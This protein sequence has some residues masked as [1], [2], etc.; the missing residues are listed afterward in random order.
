MAAPYTPDEWKAVV[1]TSGIVDCDALKKSLL[2]RSEMKFVFYNWMFNSDGTLSPAFA[3][4]ACTAL[5]SINCAEGGGTTPTTT[6]TT[7]AGT[8]TT[9]TTA[10]PSPVPVYA[11]TDQNKLITIDLVTGLTSSSLATY[12]DVFVGLAMHPTT[13]VLYGVIVSGGNYQFVIFNMLDLTYSN[14]GATFAARVEGLAFEPTGTFLYGCTGGY[15]GSV[16]TPP[17]LLK[18]ITRTTGAIATVGGGLSG[19][20]VFA[21]DV[22]FAG[23]TGLYGIGRFS[24]DIN[25]K[26]MGIDIATGAL[27]FESSVTPAEVG[28]G[29]DRLCFYSGTMYRVKGNQI[30]RVGTT[31][32]WAVSSPPVLYSTADG[33]I[34]NLAHLQ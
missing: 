16:V 14:V 1:P 25:T 29:S 10:A 3:A 24:G 30:T 12:S 22:S 13:H 19:F 4:L 27:Q 7:T 6:A 5:N 11:I 26:I 33:V 17:G 28:G 15:T 9:T 20:G 34:T 23:S 2:R 31:I 21:W 18:K 8:G 32:P